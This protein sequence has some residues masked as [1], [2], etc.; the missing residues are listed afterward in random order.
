M[1]IGQIIDLI[2]I[3]QTILSLDKNE[4]DILS[5]F[6]SEIF[7]GNLFSEAIRLAVKKI[8][9]NNIG[10]LLY[11]KSTTFIQT[12]EKKLSNLLIT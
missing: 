10:I 3:K 11:F 12:L 7:L 6:I 9:K 2:V 5:P 1:Q 8:N 4:K